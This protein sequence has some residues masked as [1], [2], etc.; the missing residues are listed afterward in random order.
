MIFFMVSP[1][2]YKFDNANNGNDNHT[3][4][5]RENTAIRHPWE[6]LKQ[7]GQKPKDEAEN[8]G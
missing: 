1:T 2:C 4:T 6:Q 7:Q 8:T 5:Q 3:G